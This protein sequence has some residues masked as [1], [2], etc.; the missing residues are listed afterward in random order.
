M[1]KKYGDMS[2]KELLQIA[3]I[4]G[5]KNRHKMKKE[6]LIKALSKSKKSLKEIKK[7]EE[8]LKRE[9]RK[10][11]LENHLELLPKEPGI[12]F[13]DWQ[14]DLKDLK[15]DEGEL[16][17][18]GNKKEILNL[19]VKISEGKGYI[20]VEEGINLKAILGFRKKNRFSPIISSE[21]I[22]V[23]R[24]SALKKG[25]LKW[26]KINTIKGKVVKKKVTIKPSKELEK[27]KEKLKKEAK[28]I[29]Y[30]RYPKEEV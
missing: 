10:K 25:T 18:I 8:D 27:E 24:K 20:K 21:P 23:P 3:K 29:K 17:L 2:Q 28:H 4:Y 14:V 26:G 30:L 15:T 5:I 12:V 13:V 6:D 11:K 16:K 19:S 22:N 9:I 7:I 1:S